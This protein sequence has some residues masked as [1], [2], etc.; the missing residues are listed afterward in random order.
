MNIRV[1]CIYLI[2]WIF[3]CIYELLLILIILIFRWNDV[4]SQIQEYRNNLLHM[5]IFIFIWINYDLRRVPCLSMYGFSE[6]GLVIIIFQSHSH[7]VHMNILIYIPL[8]L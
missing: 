8:F 5:F 6:P 7:F 2:P 4:I 1:R 3:M